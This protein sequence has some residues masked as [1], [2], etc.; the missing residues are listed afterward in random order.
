MGKY[1]INNVQ[2]CFIIGAIIL[3]KCVLLLLNCINSTLNLLLCFLSYINEKKRLK[4][5]TCVISLKRT[6]KYLSIHIKLQTR[7][8]DIKK[9]RKTFFFLVFDSNLTTNC[10][11]IVCFWNVSAWIISGGLLDYFAECPFSARGML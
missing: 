6:N 2:Y 3:T 1:R 7:A 10:P 4:Y 11:R 8:S 9:K 5:V